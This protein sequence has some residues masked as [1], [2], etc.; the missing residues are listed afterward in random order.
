ME[1]QFDV[2]SLGDEKEALRIVYRHM[3][4]LF[5]DTAEVWVKKEWNVNSLVVSVYNALEHTDKV[6]DSGVFA[7]PPE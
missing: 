2:Q 1:Q 3:L 6:F 7:N 4:S 5:H